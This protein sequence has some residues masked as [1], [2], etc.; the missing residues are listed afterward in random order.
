MIDSWPDDMGVSAFKII[1]WREACSSLDCS[2]NQLLK[3]L[4]EHDCSVVRLSTRKRGVLARDLLRVVHA[5]SR[6]AQS[7]AASKEVK[8]AAAV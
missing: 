7:Y 2:G 6:P 5:K 8:H 3:L 4:A 1:G